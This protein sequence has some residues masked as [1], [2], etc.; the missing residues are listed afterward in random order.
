MAERTSAIARFGK[1]FAQAEMTALTV[2]VAGVTLAYFGYGNAWQA[3][4]FLALALVYFLQAFQ[5]IAL[6]RPEDEK[7]GFSHLFAF[8]ITPKV[9]WI[10]CSVSL[11]G[12]LFYQLQFTARS[13]QQMMLIGAV[14][15]A[16]SMLIFL[17]VVLTNSTNSGKLAPLFYRGVP[18]LA[19][20]L[21]FL[22]R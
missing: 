8:S 9:F 20:D 1:Y 2:L 6:E 18:L 12:I 14:S 10:N 11:I 13:Y 16:I 22:L 3:F 15:L 17:P 4:G 19:L 5:I 21:F 7:L